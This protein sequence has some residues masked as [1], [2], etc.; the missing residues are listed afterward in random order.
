MSKMDLAAGGGPVAAGAKF[1]Q[2][3]RM[4]LKVGR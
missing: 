3:N 4:S 1:L 2:V